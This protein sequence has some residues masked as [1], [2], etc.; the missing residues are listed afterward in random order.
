MDNRLFRWTVKA[1]A[2]IMVRAV[3]LTMAP[4]VIEVF[5][6]DLISMFPPA[7]IAILPPALSLRFPPALISTFLSEKTVILAPHGKEADEFVLQCA[8]R[9][10]GKI[11][12]NDAYRDYYK[13]YNQQW[14][15][16]SKLT[17]KFIE[18]E[19]IIV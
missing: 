17:C 4:P 1:S 3:I 14:I 8:K 11:L 18:G 9:F 15:Y 2:A 16:N 13:N 5:A 7:S 12:S 6:P 19:F 10:K